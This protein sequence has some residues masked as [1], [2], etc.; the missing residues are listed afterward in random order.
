MLE[1]HLKSYLYQQLIKMYLKTKNKTI[2]T[3][4]DPKKKPDASEVLLT[5]LLTYKYK[6]N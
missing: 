2:I 5:L 3:T 6:K 4:F 1:Y